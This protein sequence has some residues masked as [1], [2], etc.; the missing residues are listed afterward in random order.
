R[1]VVPPLIKIRHLGSS[2]SA[3]ADRRV[4]SGLDTGS[5]LV[6]LLVAATP[7]LVASF[8]TLTGVRKEVM[9]SER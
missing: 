7:L 8:G 1:L 4:S 5:G 6:V 3:C 9:W 2:I